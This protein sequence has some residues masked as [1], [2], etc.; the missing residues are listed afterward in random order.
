MCPLS[1]DLKFPNVSVKFCR[2]MQKI[3][4]EWFDIAPFRWYHIKKIRSILIEEEILKDFS[5]NITKSLKPVAY[6]KDS[7]GIY[8][9]LGAL[10]FKSSMATFKVLCHELAHI[11]LSQQSFYSD[12][13]RLNKE[14]KTKYSVS[15]KVYLSSPIELYAMVVSVELMKMIRASLTKDFEIKRINKFIDLECAK[16]NDLIEFIKTL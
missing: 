8:I 12:L 1:F 6:M 3:A 5:V 7:D 11:W 14:F 2:K 10:F 13:K 15:E 4:F 16:I 9:S